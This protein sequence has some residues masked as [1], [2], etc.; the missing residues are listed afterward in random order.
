VTS[1][2]SLS[3]GAREHQA[4]NISRLANAKVIC[5]LAADKCNVFRKRFNTEQEAIDNIKKIKKKYNIYDKQKI[6]TKRI[7]SRHRSG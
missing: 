5:I 2:T 1:P 3:N 4:V 6:K 7:K